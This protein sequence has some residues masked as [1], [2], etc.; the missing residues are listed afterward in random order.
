M[1]RVLFVLMCVL[2]SLQGNRTN[3]RTSI[4]GTCLSCCS[5]GQPNNVRTPGGN[6]RFWKRKIAG[7]PTRFSFLLSRAHNAKRDRD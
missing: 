3:A 5:L 4:P 1:S 2:C 7:K 6:V